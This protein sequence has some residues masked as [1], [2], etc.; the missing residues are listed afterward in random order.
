MNNKD[1]HDSGPSHLSSR[2][3]VG[4]NGE[5]VLDENSLSSMATTEDTSSSV[6]DMREKVADINALLEEV[7]P[8]SENDSILETEGMSAESLDEHKKLMESILLE[9][10]EKRKEEK[11]KV[12]KEMTEQRYE[13]LM[14]LLGKSQLYSQLLHEKM[15]ELRDFPSMAIRKGRKVKGKENA[16]ETGKPKR[17]RKGINRDLSEK[18]DSQEKLKLAAGEHH[19]EQPSLLENVTLRPYQI[20]GYKWLKHMAASGLSGI[21]AD[22]M[23][24]GKTLQ[25]IANICDMLENGLEGPFLVVAPLS[26]LSNWLNE[27]TQFAPKVSVVLYHGPAE[28][29]WELSQK[30]SAAKKVNGHTEYPV[31]ITSYELIIADVKILSQPMWKYLVV[32]EGHR[33]KNYKSRLSLELKKYSSMNRLLLT[34]TPLQNDLTELWSLLNFLMPEIFDDL[35]VFQSW[36]D[37]EEIKSNSKDLIEREKSK[38]IITTLH[39]IL[40]P[41]LLRRLKSD[42]ALELPPKKE[43]IVYCP[44]AKEQEEMYRAIVNKAILTIGDLNKKKKEEEESQILNARGR[45]KRKSHDRNF[46]D[47]FDTGADTDEKLDSWIKMSLEADEYRAAKRRKTEERQSLVRMKFQNP[48]MLLRKCVNHP[49]LCEWPMDENGDL[50][51]DERLTTRSGKMMVLDQMLQRLKKE[52][53]KVLIFSQMVITMDLIA[54]F[55]DM[56]GLSWLRLDGAMK[57]EERVENIR[58]FN[59]DPEIFVF[60]LSTRAG[61]LGVNLTSADTV[62]IY[63]SDWNPQADLQAQ[64]RCHRIGQKRPVVVYR[65]SMANSKETVFSLRKNGRLSLIEVIFMHPKE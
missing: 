58:R 62:I 40:Q 52:N 2:S 20:E 35:D 15:K 18:A 4:K 41:F 63:D 28:K 26:T 3:S 17:A 46:K 5:P 9:E 57:L 38:H 31:V 24:L 14:D 53:H 1:D 13:R 16:H 51:V 11:E 37:L 19:E 55:L 50:A 49:F 61:G 36:F 54:D 60:L 8:N 48:M 43:L 42:V 59:T 47:Y 10:A 33:I 21:L 32:D 7:S 39:N 56:R 12:D 44:M 25:C 6:L 34:G 45:P 27:F 64:D 23:G 65:A 30:I 29:R 22:E